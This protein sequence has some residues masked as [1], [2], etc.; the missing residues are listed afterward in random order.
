LGPARGAVL[1]RSRQNEREL[2]MPY[3]EVYG[4]RT[5]E[6]SKLRTDVYYLLK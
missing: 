4:E 6:P 5:D 2:S 3:W 1:E